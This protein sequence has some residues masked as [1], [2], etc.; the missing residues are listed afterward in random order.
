M[1]IIERFEDDK[2]VLETDKGKMVISRSELPAAAREGDILTCGR[3]GWSV[4]SIATYSRRSA[5]KNKLRRLTEKN[6]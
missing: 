4:D 3:N 1:T 2:A 6:D 5:M